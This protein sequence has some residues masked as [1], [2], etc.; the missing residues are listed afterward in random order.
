M[1]LS[2]L[3]SDIDIAI[4]G[5][6]INPATDEL[7]RERYP[8]EDTMKISGHIAGD[9]STNYFNINGE[10]IDIGSDMLHASHIDLSKAK[11]VVAIA[12]GISKYSSIL[13][14]LKTGIITDIITDVETCSKILENE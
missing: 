7:I 13:G 2:S 3:W 4:V 9:I 1:H 5:P 11:R 12:G 14:A 6:G 8:G 10:V